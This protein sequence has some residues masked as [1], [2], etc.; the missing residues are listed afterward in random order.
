MSEEG[1]SSATMV[2]PQLDG[3]K[4]TYTILGSVGKVN[5][6]IRLN[7]DLGMFCSTRDDLDDDSLIEIKVVMPDIAARL[8]R[9]TGVGVTIG[10]G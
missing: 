9:A 2:H 8:F 5:R 6:A 3:E 1:C 10:W 4:S 7:P